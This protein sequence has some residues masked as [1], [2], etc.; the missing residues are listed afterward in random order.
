MT[1]VVAGSDVSI[2]CGKQPTWITHRLRWVHGAFA[3]T[4][5]LIPDGPD[6]RRHSTFRLPLWRRFIRHNRLTAHIPE[7]GDSS[8]LSF[9]IRDCT[10][11]HRGDYVQMGGK[12]EYKVF[13]DIQENG[14]QGA[15][16]PREGTYVVQLSAESRLFRNG[17]C[18]ALLHCHSGTIRGPS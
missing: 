11:V 18:A 9:P 4:L 10:R 5:F 14:W 15:K 12:H 3:L 16:S 2:P 13:S 8:I 7:T 17:R 6:R 1:V